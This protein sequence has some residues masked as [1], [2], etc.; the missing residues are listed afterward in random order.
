[1][2]ATPRRNC[3]SISELHTTTASIRPD[4]AHRALHCGVAAGVTPLSQLA[5]QPHG[6]EARESRE[7]LAQ[8]R[9]KGIGALLSARSR[10]IGWRLQTAGDAGQH[11]ARRRGF[12]AAPAMMVPTRRGATNTTLAATQRHR[13]RSGMVTA[14]CARSRSRPET[15]VAPAALKAQRK[16]LASTCLILVSRARGA[17]DGG[18][19]R[20]DAS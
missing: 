15:V 13:C 9:Q 6:G 10:T 11:G 12:G 1:M 17:D 18:R 16:L 14:D 5:P 20:R 8:I 2:I 3:R 19:W 7:T 4:V